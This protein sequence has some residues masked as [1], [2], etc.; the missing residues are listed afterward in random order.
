M[1]KWRLHWQSAVILTLRADKHTH[2]PAA[3][4]AHARSRLGR[5]YISVRTSD[6]IRD[7]SMAIPGPQ[8]DY[9]GVT[10]R[11]LAPQTVV[12]KRKAWRVYPVV[13]AV[14]ATA[15]ATISRALESASQILAA[16]RQHPLSY[17]ATARHLQQYS[18]RVESGCSTVITTKRS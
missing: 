6:W 2:L 18:G 16:V 1:M 7:I 15:D 8:S 12:Q 11:I 13:V 5:W 4:G 10:I 9:N 3:G 17:F 14:R